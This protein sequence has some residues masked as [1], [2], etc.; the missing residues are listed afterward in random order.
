MGVTSSPVSGAAH[1]PP[2]AGLAAVASLRLLLETLA[3]LQVEHARMQG[4]SWQPIAEAL[5]VSKQLVHKK[6]SG[7][8]R[9][10]GRP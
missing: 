5:G 2:A 7:G 9:R 6:Y 10:S 8:R 3:Q 4:W 1:L